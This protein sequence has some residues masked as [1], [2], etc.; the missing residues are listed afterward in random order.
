TSMFTCCR[1]GLETSRRMTASMMSSRNMTGK[2]RMFLL[3]GDQKRRWPKRR[4]NYA[5]SSTSFL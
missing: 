3:N 2:V 5:A 4:Q 1:G